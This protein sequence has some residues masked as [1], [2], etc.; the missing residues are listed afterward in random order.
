MTD[1]S[2]I[3]WH[4]LI[5]FRTN[6]RRSLPVTGPL[7]FPRF[8]EFCSCQIQDAVRKQRAKRRCL[9][10]TWVV[11]G[12]RSSE[13]GEKVK[14]R[15]QNRAQDR[16]I[17]YRRQRLIWDNWVTIERKKIESLQSTTWSFQV[18]RRYLVSC[19]KGI[20][21]RGFTG[22]SP[23]WPRADPQWKGWEHVKQG[24]G[25]FPCTKHLKKK[26]GS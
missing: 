8:Q 25:P 23:L 7:C 1:F 6:W 17:T 13:W 19:R 20:V 22:L 10:V 2:S 9:I 18:Y 3:L 12:S 11:P 15:P 4:I 5:G 24:R 14:W 21:L 16:H 26:E